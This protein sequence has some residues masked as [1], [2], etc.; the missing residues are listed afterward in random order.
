MERIKTYKTWLR[1]LF[2]LTGCLAAMTAVHAASVTVDGINYTTNNKGQ[3][4][5][6]K[7]TI[8]KAS[9]DTPA[10]TAFYTGD[11]VI[12]ETITVD[13]ATYT[14]VAT[15]SNAFLDCRDVTSVILPATCV[16]IG[17]QTFK[18]CTSLKNSPIPATAT[19]V[20]TGVFNGCTSLE[21]VTIVPGWKRLLSQDLANC[22]SLKRLIISAG[23]TPLEMKIDA[24]GPNAEARAAINSIE[25]IYMGRDVDA[26]KYTS[27]EQPFHNMGA[28][29][30]VV[31]GGTTTTIQGTTFQGCT[32]LNS[33]TFESDN[34]VTSIG[35]SAFA[36]CTSLQAVAIPSGVTTIE[37]SV[38]NG[39]RN[40]QHVSMSDNV[41]SIGVTAFYN[42]SLTSATFHLPS[43]L[44]SIGQ[45][46]FENTLLANSCCPHRWQR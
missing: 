29:K 31:I 3:A 42:T 4:T 1:R 6:A 27:A 45:S 2:M 18:G 15:A 9:G 38:F 8:T 16:T 46:A 19:S 12:P 36:G 30:T 5:V 23:P 25:Y 33:L 17:R 39:C 34:V 32:A 40:L 22:P 24:F 37:Q 44:T 28:L 26:S 14:V 20:D 10:D 21:E 41:T 7:Y 11:I 13:G 35:T 43:A